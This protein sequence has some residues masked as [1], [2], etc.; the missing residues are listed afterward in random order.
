M[1]WKIP[2]YRKIALS[3]TIEIREQGYFPV[4]GLRSSYMAPGKKKGTTAG[5]K[6]ARSVAREW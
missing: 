5:G 6:H 1:S 4:G 3:P 2:N